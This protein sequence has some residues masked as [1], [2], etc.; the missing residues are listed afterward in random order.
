MR[1]DYKIF[2]EHIKN[3]SKVIDIGCGEGDF[4]EILKNEKNCHTFGI[5]LEPERVA[6]ALGKGISVVQGDADVDL[7]S[8]PARDANT[9]FDYAILANT[10]QVMK[11]TK[12]ALENARKISRKVMVSI[13]N[14]GYIENRFHL[15]FSGRMPVTKQLSYE[16]FE[17]P[18]IHF[19]TI[20]D[21]IDLALRVGFTI[22]RSYYVDNGGDVKEFSYE[23]SNI[24]NLFGKSGIF[25]L[26]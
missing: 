24:A 12:T 21:F 8:Y 9:G 20:R 19:S 23:N 1:Q 5:E 2:L 4:L 10:L 17:T 14:F 13:P 11:Q 18:N 16:W 22:D 3:Y 26:S 6:V 7:A 15:L 25:I